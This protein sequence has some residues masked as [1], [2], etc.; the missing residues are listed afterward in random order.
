[1]V[2]AMTTDEYNR[3][4]IAALSHAQHLA[5]ARSGNAFA[6]LLAERG[7]GSP[8]SSKYRRWIAG[9][10]IV[11]AGAIQVATE[12]AGTTVQALFDGPAGSQP[13]AGDWQARVEDAI[14]R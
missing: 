10:P 2:R 6:R 9:E 8:S 13:T 4:A 12:V 3:R 1:M 7:H 14:G 5:G 11:P